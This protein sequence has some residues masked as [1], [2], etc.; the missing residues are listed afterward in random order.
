MITIP[1]DY[2]DIFYEIFDCIIAEADDTSR[3]LRALSNVLEC[4]FSY[5]NSEDWYYPIQYA[6]NQLKEVRGEL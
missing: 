4:M 5:R 2:A 1:D 3:V 6:K